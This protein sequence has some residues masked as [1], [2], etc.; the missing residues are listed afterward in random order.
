MTRVN[1][2]SVQ[3]FAFAHPR[4]WALGSALVLALTA[5]SISVQA[6]T[7]TDLHNFNC[8]TDGCNPQY[9]IVAQGRDGNLYSSLPAGGANS[10]GTVYKSTHSGTLGAIYPFSAADG[11]GPSS[12]LTLGEDGNFYGAT[13]GGGAN[14][15]GTLFKITPTGTPTVLHDFTAAEGG[16]A[17]AAPVAD[18]TGKTFYGVTYYG[19]AYSITPSMS[20]KLLPNPIP[21]SSRAPLILAS[22]GN[23]YGTTQTGGTGYGT[24][25]RLSSNGAVKVI[26]TFDGTHGYYP[27][28]PVIQG[29]DG[30]LYGTTYEGG[31]IANAA[32]VVFKLSTTG[33]I[34]V[35]HQFDST[36]TTDGYGPFGGLVEG[37][38]GNLYGTTSIGTGNGT[39]TAG[40]IFKISKTGT[41]YTIL[42]GF[43]STH[44]G[45]PE[46]TPI[47]N[48]NGIIYGETYAGGPGSGGVF[49]SLDAGF[50]PFVSMVG[51][52]AGTP[53]QTIQ[54]L[55]QGFNTATGVLFGTGSATFSVVSDT[56][57]TAA[58]PVE[59]TQG[60]IT[61]TTR[62]GTLTSNKTFAVIPSIN[63]FTPTSG[64][65]G[66]KVTIAGGGFHGATKVS[67]GGVKATT[68]SIDS[69][70]QIIATVP[71]G[72]VTGK[73][74]VTTPG[75]TATSKETF[76]VN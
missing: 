71:T 48:T 36:S 6:Q 46:T 59:G 33:K 28:A 5:L 65:V 3:K 19:R 16:G 38:D 76:T 47:L 45:S 25:F 58:I 75:G 11:A 51:F 2:S 64:P 69:G 40:E 61:V 53:G 49:Y 73:I 12:G 27:Y 62:S 50:S 39:L 43:D 4:T 35:L 30:F 18:K 32:G 70:A 22:D 7:F 20:F 57:M 10:L 42:H 23:F 72:A 24:V 31:S 55:G 13:T 17:F 67:F 26:Y 14:N 56:Y 34:T 1:P 15:Y 68:F 52:P 54:I 41:G 44:G 29:S 74:Q 37:P 21:G 9:G 63:T 66:L 8:N 60:Y